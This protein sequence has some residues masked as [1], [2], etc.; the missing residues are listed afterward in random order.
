MAVRYL[1]LIYPIDARRQ[2]S[3]SVIDMEIVA[4]PRHNPLRGVSG[5]PL[6][7]LLVKVARPAIL[8]VAHDCRLATG[9]RSKRGTSVVD[10]TFSPRSRSISAE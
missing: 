6:G 7:R 8:E 9:T 3:F 2:A 1:L 10:V 5:E 4:L